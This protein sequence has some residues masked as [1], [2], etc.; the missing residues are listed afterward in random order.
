[1]GIPLEN[2]ISPESVRRLIWSS[3]RREFDSESA[4]E[5]LSELGVRHWQV[6]LASDIIVRAL[7]ESEPLLVNPITVD[8][9]SA[10]SQSEEE[11]EE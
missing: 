1:L 8:G 2:L 11:R 7:Q 6:N 9:E 4:K 5:F 10:D 3:E